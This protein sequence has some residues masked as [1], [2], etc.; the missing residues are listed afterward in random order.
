[1]GRADS[2]LDLEGQKGSF[3]SRLPGRDPVM[4]TS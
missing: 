2:E 3:E 1:L 4:R